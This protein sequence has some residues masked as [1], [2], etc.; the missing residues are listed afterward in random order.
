MVQIPRLE[1][2]VESSWGI[3]AYAMTWSPSGTLRG[4]P[5]LGVGKE[6]RGTMV[7]SG[8]Q[9]LS[10]TIRSSSPKDFHLPVMEIGHQ[11]YSSG[12]LLVPCKAALPLFYMVLAGFQSQSSTGC[13]PTFP[14]DSLSTVLCPRSPTDCPSPYDKKVSLPCL[15]AIHLWHKS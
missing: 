8:W 10:D 1:A 12:N 2:S 9:R 11:T 13:V 4:A 5:P 14:L 15:S 7:G 3:K 6:G